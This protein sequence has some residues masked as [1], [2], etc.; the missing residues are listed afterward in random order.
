MEFYLVIAIIFFEG[1][2]LAYTNNIQKTTLYVGK[3]IA[4]GNELASP[5][6]GFQDAITPKAQNYRN[7]TS[8]ILLA[9]IVILA[10]RIAWYWI[11]VA[12][13]VTFTLSTIV[14]RLFLPRSLSFY[15]KLIFQDL[16]NRSATYRKKGD[17]DRADAAKDVGM[18]V[19]QVLAEAVA[20]KTKISEIR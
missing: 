7:W 6:N 19:G 16:A 5:R 15:I 11:P 20:K 18:D 8:F 2:L 9:A 1:I 13:F 3:K 17:T 10:L 4:E 12:I 14:A